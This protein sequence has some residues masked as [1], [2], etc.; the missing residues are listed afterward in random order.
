MSFVF[1]IDFSGA[2]PSELAFETPTK[3]EL[4]I[5]FET[6]KELGLTILGSFLLCCSNHRDDYPFR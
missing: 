5:K 3:F 6:A 1:L 4:V 2:S